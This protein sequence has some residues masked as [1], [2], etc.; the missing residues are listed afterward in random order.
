MNK[1]MFKLAHQFGIQCA[2][3]YRKEAISNIA[4]QSK[5]N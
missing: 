4:K 2:F 1:T 5:N 3:F